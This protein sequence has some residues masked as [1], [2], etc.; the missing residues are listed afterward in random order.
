MCARMT[1]AVVL[2]AV[3]LFDKVLCCS[4]LLKSLFWVDA[5]L[6]EKQGIFFIPVFYSINSGAGHQN[7]NTHELLL[8]RKGQLNI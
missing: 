5:L 1:N 7:A 6:F 8:P 4:Y 3:S 2:L